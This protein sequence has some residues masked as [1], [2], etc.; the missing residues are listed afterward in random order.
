MGSKQLMIHNSVYLRLKMFKDANN[1]KSFSEA[2]WV[3]LKQYN[4]YWFPG[5][6]EIPM[7]PDMNNIPED[8]TFA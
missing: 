6:T 8:V 7:M 4:R 5:E 2:I 1:L 3:L